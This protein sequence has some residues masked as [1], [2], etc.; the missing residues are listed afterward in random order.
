VG[1]GLV[2]NVGV[3]PGFFSS[4]E[5]SAGLLRA[6]TQYAHQRAG[7][8]YTEPGLMR[9]RRG[10][11]TIIRTLSQPETVEGRTI[12]LLSP[13]LAVAP[14]R[15]IPARSQAFLYELPSGPVPRVGFVSGRLQAEVETPTTTGFFARGPLNT[16][17]AARLHAGGKQIAGAKATDRFGRTVEVTTTQEGDTV[18]VQYPNHPDGVLVRVG[19]R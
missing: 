6:L 14:S 18:L 9:V 4:S 5:R 12:D 11:Y 10:R 19:W 3:A 1:K 2:L 17:G 7:G 13:T 8:N 16:T 15:T